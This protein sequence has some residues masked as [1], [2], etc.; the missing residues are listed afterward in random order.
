LLALLVVGVVAALAFIG[1]RIP[2]APPEGLLL[3]QYEAG[4]VAAAFLALLYRQLDLGTVDM[5]ARGIV[6]GIIGLCIAMMWFRK[7][8]TFTYSTRP[9]ALRPAWPLLL[10]SLLAFVVSAIA[11]FN[12]P[13]LGGDSFNQADA[14]VLLFGFFGLAWLPGVAVILGLRAV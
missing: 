3:D 9:V 11:A 5:V 2:A 8:S 10:G 13:V 4:F 12:A 1:T 7:D 14:V 6:V